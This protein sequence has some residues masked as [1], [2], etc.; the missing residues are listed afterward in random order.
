MS[1]SQASLKPQ[2]PTVTSSATSDIPQNSNSNALS[3][4]SEDYTEQGFTFHFKT[5]ISAAACLKHAGNCGMEKYLMRVNGPSGL[6]KAVFIRCVSVLAI[7]TCTSQSGAAMCKQPVQICAGE[8][9]EKH[10][11][12]LQD[13]KSGFEN[14]IARTAAISKTRLKEN[15]T[16]VV[17]VITRNHRH[18]LAWHHYCKTNQGL[19]CEILHLTCFIYIPAHWWRLP[20]AGL[21]NPGLDLWFQRG[22]SPSCWQAIIYC[23]YAKPR[24]RSHS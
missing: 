5:A 14:Q 3:Q 19:C 23:T 9:A 10:R 18:C 2:V 16:R 6:V 24:N 13:S 21:T 12:P 20:W 22:L 15:K 11:S 4:G 1:G 17:D 7:K 8:N